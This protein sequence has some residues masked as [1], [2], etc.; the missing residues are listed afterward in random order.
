MLYDLLAYDLCGFNVRA[1]PATEELE[2]QKKLTLPVPESWWLD[3]LHRGYI[4]RSKIGLEFVFG[5]WFDAA[6]TELLFASYAE[7]VRDHHDRHPLHR[8]AFGGSWRAWGRNRPGAVGCC[9]A[10]T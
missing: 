4:W 8:E 10:N 3:V 2:R 5:T 7:F 1:V 6:S 9:W